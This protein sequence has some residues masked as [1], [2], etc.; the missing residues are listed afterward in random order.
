M[1]Y[2]VLKF[3]L[4]IAQNKRNPNYGL[5]NISLYRTD[6]PRASLPGAVPGGHEPGT[7]EINYPN[8][9]ACLEETGYA[10]LVGF[11]LIP[12]TTTNQAVKAIRKL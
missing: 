12:K 10:G 4:C 1:C 8:V 2:Y 9:F 11:E 5:S 6:V 3:K 7:G